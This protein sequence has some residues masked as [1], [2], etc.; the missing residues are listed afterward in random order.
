M[1]VSNVDNTKIRIWEAG[2]RN[3]EYGTGDI[4]Y[5]DTLETA[6]RSLQNSHSFSLQPSFQKER[7]R[8]EFDTSS[9]W[10]LS[11]RTSC[12]SITN[13]SLWNTPFVS[14]SRK[15]I[16][17]LIIVSRKSGYSSRSNL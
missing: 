8:M 1:K 14:A 6:S 7:L 10:F 13:F 15:S 12:F 5:V 4:A 9:S 17:P 2:T 3:I 16:S 11:S